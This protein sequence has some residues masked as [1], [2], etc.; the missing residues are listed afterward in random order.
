MPSQEQTPLPS[1]DSTNY[2]WSNS[3]TFGT[4]TQGP[5]PQLPFPSEHEDT[6]QAPLPLTSTNLDQMSLNSK[7]SNGSLS[8]INRYLEAP[9]DPETNAVLNDSGPLPWQSFD[10]TIDVAVPLPSASPSLFSA[11]LSASSGSSLQSAGSHHSGRRYESSASRGSRQERRKHPYADPKKGG[12]TAKFACVFCK[13][14]CKILY[15]WRRHEESAHV[16]PIEFICEDLE[17][18]CINVKCVYCGMGD[19][20]W[21]KGRQ[22]LYANA[23]HKPA[24]YQKTEAERTFTRKDHLVQH[25]RYVHNAPNFSMDDRERMNGPG[26]SKRK[27]DLHFVWTQQGT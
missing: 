21:G 12:K 11:G 13:T 10:G 5:W 27:R 2:N 14:P 15:E 23:N 25:I 17:P 18:M 19:K 6:T 7:S 4:E 1:L 24:C 9:I 22:H 3:N 20:S 26:W 8:S 16:S